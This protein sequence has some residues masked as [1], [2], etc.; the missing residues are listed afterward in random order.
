MAACTQSM[1][2]V[3]MLR[4]SGGNRSAKRWLEQDH[5][6]REGKDPVEAQ[7]VNARGRLVGKGMLVQAGHQLAQV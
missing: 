3:K 2:C 4:R 6:F 1:D 5:R 7:Q